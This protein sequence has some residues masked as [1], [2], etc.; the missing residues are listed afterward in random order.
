M[1]T[2]YDST[3]LGHFTRILGSEDPERGSSSR[4]TW[5]D[6]G[7]LSVE[8]FEKHTKESLKQHGH[9]VF[10]R[11][12]NYRD[13]VVVHERLK[14]AK[15]V[16]SVIMSL[17][18]SPDADPAPVWRCSGGHEMSTATAPPRSLASGRRCDGCNDALTQGELGLR[19]EPC[20][21]DL[22]C[23]CV[24]EVSSTPCRVLFGRSAG[25][26]M[27]YPPS[28]A[29]NAVAR[30]HIGGAVGAGLGELLAQLAGGGGGA[31]GLMN[32]LGQMLQGGGQNTKPG[33]KQSFIDSL[34][35]K[36]VG[37]DNFD[38]CK[39]DSCVICMSEFL[40]GEIVTSLPCGHWFHSGKMK[41]PNEG[42]EVTNSE[43]AMS[44]PSHD[45]AHDK[46]SRHFCGRYEGQRGYEKAC[47][48]CDS[49]CG[50]KTGNLCKYGYSL[51]PDT[52]V[53]AE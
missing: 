21:Y 30:R 5:N 13:A 8:Q 51:E 53:A 26:R 42:K 25:E 31:E 11:K 9:C 47:G 4:F 7:W 52:V 41:G 2:W 37:A 23:T 46:E 34:V 6:R 29:G 15:F 48:R 16:S 10:A 27:E 38:D 49:T 20:D 40:D 18:L 3:T 43:G 17:S 50:P 39:T 12:I 45:W 33:T 35:H 44:R 36:T 24:N 14:R 22:C 19:C 28:A 1:D 32:A